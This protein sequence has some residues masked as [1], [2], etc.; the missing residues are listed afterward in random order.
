MID[1]LLLHHKSLNK[2]KQCKKMS[3]INFYRIFIDYVFLAKLQNVQFSAQVFVVVLFTKNVF[4]V[5]TM[6]HSLVRIIMHK[7]LINPLNSG[8]HKKQ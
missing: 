1:R 3:R 2:T 7:K 8:N 6:E 4:N 5:L